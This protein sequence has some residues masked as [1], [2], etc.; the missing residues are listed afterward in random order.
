M[1]PEMDGH[2][3]L[4]GLRESTSTDGI[5]VIMLTAALGADGCAPSFALPV[6]GVLA[7]PFDIMGLAGDVAALMGWDL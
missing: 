1:M 6:A 2:A 5:P 4:R 7:K 3:T